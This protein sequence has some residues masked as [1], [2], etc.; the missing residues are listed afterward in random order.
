MKFSLQ[1]LKEFK[2]TDTQL[3]CTT[4][5]VKP[6]H[7]VMAATVQNYTQR[8]VGFTHTEQL[9]Y[10]NNMR[11]HDPLDVDTIDGGNHSKAIKLRNQFDDDQQVTKIINIFKNNNYLDDETNSVLSI[12]LGEIFQNFYAHSDCA[13][14]P[15]CCV[16]DWKKSPYIEIAIADK[17]IGINKS[18]KDI[19]KEHSDD[20]NPCRLAC[21]NGIS[22]KLDKESRIGTKHSG[23][24]LYYTKRFI[25]E[26]KGGLFL[27]SSNQCYINIPSGEFDEKLPYKWRGTVVR[28]VINKHQIVESEKFFRLVCKEQE[29]EDYDDFF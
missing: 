27:F 15:I 28:L 3:I 4:K 9:M 13:Q 29:G 12:I 22:S 24:G 10:A 6:V 7:I 5:F 18:L 21:E 2:L 19:L 17:G 8:S 16:Q 23:Y 26:N 14:P 25:E 1:D 20:T 11:Y